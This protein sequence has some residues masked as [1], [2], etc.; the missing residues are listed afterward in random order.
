MPPK[1]CSACVHP[2]RKQIDLALA[3]GVSLSATAKAHG[4]H[5]STVTTHRNKHLAAAVHAAV[6]ADEANHGA[7]LLHAVSDLQ[8]K[9]MG[10]LDA[11]LE[12]TEGFL[13]R[14]PRP[15]LALRAI[16]EARA[17]VE[18]MARLQGDLEDGAP[19]EVRVVFE[20]DWR[21]GTE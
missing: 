16:R 3:S 20:D 15:E 7:E 19:V 10:I 13:G 12:E 18:L 2:Q 8:A 17:N 11:A 14:K 6:A 4:L 1:P 21:A 5:R 9:T